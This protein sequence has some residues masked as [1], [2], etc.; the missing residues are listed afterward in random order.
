MLEHGNIKQEV[1]QKLMEAMDKLEANKL[2]PKPPMPID[3]E[4]KTVIIAESSPEEAMPSEESAPS[5]EAV[6]P[7]APEAEMDGSDDPEMLAKLKALYE[8]IA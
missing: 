8:Q 2:K 6:A 1:L 5:E 7:E 3:S 4:E